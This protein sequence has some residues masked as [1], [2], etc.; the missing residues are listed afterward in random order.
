M[1]SSLYLYLLMP[2][3][4]GVVGWATNVIALK[5]T[6]YPIEFLGPRLWQPEGSPFGLF[7]WQG[8]IPAKAA[9]MAAKTVHLM[10][11]KL[12]DLQEV[13]SRIDPDE[14][15][16]VMEKG[17]L[18]ML[19]AIVNTT[20]R[21]YAPRVWDALPKDVRDEI[22]FKL[23]DDS[24]QMLR[25][26]MHEVREDVSAVLD[27]EHMVVSTVTRDK[28]I[29]N[30]IFLACG[31]E[32]F[33]FIE[34]SG[35]YFGFLFGIAQTLAWWLY[36]Q[37]WLLPVC[38]FVNGYATNAFALK[39]IFQPL[40]PK[41]CCGLTVH[42]LFL[43]RQREVSKIFAERITQDVM[44]THRLWMA[45]LHGPR[46][47]VF[48]RKLAKH[49]ELFVNDNLGPRL[50][51]VLE[52]QLG[53]ETAASMKRQ[54][55]ESI[56]EQLPLHIAYSYDY[57]TEALRLE[58]TLRTAMQEL[59]YAEFE[60]VLHPV[61]EEDELKLILVGGFLGAAVGLFQ[62]VVMFGGGGS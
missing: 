47:E 18:R 20:A 49:V 6:F 39:I 28:M 36:P 59:S 45:I 22:I 57:T 2:F 23:L 17:L 42:G 15:S 60:G 13:F 4:S 9:Q 5:M 37:S 40:E 50:R 54:I 30:R 43:R 29:I 44:T 8:I 56:C 53:E 16:R 34:R 27:L 25:A 7:G 55:A 19:D 24:P 35:F 32:E 31:A 52:K 21:A 41:R 62:L 10:T 48:D 3:I 12:I 14:F 38:G 11:T 26:F 46:H 1:D 61:F 58:E 33:V 51:K